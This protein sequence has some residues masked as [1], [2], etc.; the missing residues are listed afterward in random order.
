MYIVI[1]ILA[2]KINFIGTTVD[3]YIFNNCTHNFASARL[4]ACYT[5]DKYCQGWLFLPL[6]FVIN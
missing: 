1:S 3:L 4:T 6:I 5:A 2:F